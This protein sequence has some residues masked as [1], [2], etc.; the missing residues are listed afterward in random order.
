MDET[1]H[2]LEGRRERYP[3]ERYPVQH[4]SAQFHLGVALAHAGRVDEAV[5]ALERAAELF[6]RA[7]LRGEQAKA[8]NALGAA[9]RLAGDL[10]GAERA[11][12]DAA[13][14]FEHERH[15]LE[16]GAA[17]FNL[18]LVVR[19]RDPSRATAAFEQARRL[20]RPAPRR[21]AAAARE[22]GTALL[23]LG[24]A[25]GAE[26]ALEEAL[27]LAEG[28]GD[29]AGRGAAANALGLARLAAEKTDGAIEAFRLAAAAH[30]R[31]VRPH[32]YA[33]AKANLALAFEQGADEARARLAARQ[34]LGIAEPPG[35]VA[36]QAEAALARLGSGGG[37]LGVV[38]DREP[39]ERW[40]A[41]VREEVVR[42]A[43]AA[44]DVRRAESASWIDVQL[45]RPDE[46]PELAEAWL[47]ALLEL[48]PRLMEL[49]IRS[50]LE[51]LGE[52]EAGVR[53][54]FGSD[55]SAGMARFYVP[56]LERLRSIFERL[57]AELGQEPLWS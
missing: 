17:L 37:D 43:D 15:P 35:P 30:P 16:Q 34:A 14:A 24:D 26:Q 4:A 1:I 31:G 49:V 57:A 29:E 13:E 11:F 52:R 33:M 53:D 28:S 47:G 20:L 51:A 18:G 32:D 19:D 9:L 46:A 21:A 41:L 50:T 22:L 45:T 5:A 3:A 7:G 48:P 38:L 55:V 2:E 54:R 56:Q 36:A 42:W 39:S 23:A 6:E 12:A 10:A 40:P 25:V 8:G 44:P 27:A